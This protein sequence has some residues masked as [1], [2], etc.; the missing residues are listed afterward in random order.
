MA[1]FMHFHLKIN[2]AA[3]E[4]APDDE[5]AKLMVRDDGGL[6]CPPEKARAII[7]F[8]LAQGLQM[9]PPCD[10]QT[11]IGACLGHPCPVPETGDEATT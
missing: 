5:L 3:Y 7:R 4:R 1:G 2:L 6:P 8:W 11:D 9:G 10:N